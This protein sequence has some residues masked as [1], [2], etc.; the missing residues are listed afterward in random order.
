LEIF[1]SKGVIELLEGTMP[2]VKYLGDPGW[3][4]G[5]SGAKWQNVST[6]G[7][8]KPELLAGKKYT[9]RHTL[10]ILDLIE[11]IEKNRPPLD[12]AETARET[13]EMILAVFESHRLGRPVDLPLKNR[14]HPLTL[15]K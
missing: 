12:S 15:L 13:T 5:R 6:A 2:S 3:S 11:A 9:A 8:G 7:I 10:G 4:P 1:G 14:R